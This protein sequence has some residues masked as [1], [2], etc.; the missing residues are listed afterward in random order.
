MTR[1][2]AWKIPKPAVGDHIAAIGYSF[3]DEKG[4]ALARIE[5]LIIADK[6]YGLR[7]A[8]GCHRR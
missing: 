7:S 2:D 4:A 5:Y 3:K 1:I 6:V 8:P